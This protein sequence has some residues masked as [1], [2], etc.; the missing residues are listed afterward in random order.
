[1]K[2]SSPNNFLNSP[3][4]SSFKPM[5]NYRLLNNIFGWIT[6]VIATVVYMLTVEPTV[7]YWDCGEFI[8][9]AYKL[10]V[11][12]PPGAPLFMMIAR[13]FTLMAGDDVTQVAKWVNILSGLCSSF[14]IL[15]LFWS[16]TAF[17]KKIV[18]KSGELDQGKTIAIVGSGLVG[19]LAYTFT[20]SFWFSA[21]EGEVYAMSSFFTAI[22]FWMI[23][24]WESV[25]DE[26]HSD[27]WLILIAYTMG[28]SIGVHLLN[29]LAIPALA[30]VYYF[31]KYKPTTKGVFI[32]GGIGVGT[33]LFIQYGIIP[34]VVSIAS[35]FELFFVNSMGLP[36]NSGLIIYAILIVAVLA[37]G[38]YYTTK[39]NPMPIANTLLLAFT[40][41]L[42]GYSSYALIVIRSSA[43]PPMDENDPSNVFSL[44]AYLNREQYGDR[45]L[46][47]GQYYNT[48]M[49]I[50]REKRQYKMEDGK[51]VYY[52]G[53]KDG[54]DSYLIGDDRKESIPVYVKEL[55][56]FFPRMYS[57]QSHHIQSYKSWA[58][59][60]GKKVRLKNRPDVDE[61]V[62]P[63]FVENLTFFFK[64][65][66][67]HMYFRYFMWNFAGR[68]NNIQ[69]H[70]GIVEGNWI[71][72]IPF[73]DNYLLGSQ[74]GLPDDMAS[75]HGRNHF[76]LLPLILGLI[77]IYYQFSWDSKDGFVV[78]LLF[79]FTGLAIVLYLN[80]YPNQPRERDY[81]YAASFY[82]F[83]IWIG[84]AVLAIYDFLSK[85]V[86]ASIS[87]AI[88]T[89]ACL[90]AAPVVLASDGWNDHDRSG[91]YMAHDLAHNYLNSC[92]PNA[93]LFT[94]G[95]NDTFPLW[96]AQEVEGIRTDVRVVNLSLL[97]TDWYINQMKRRAYESAPLPISFTE[98]QIRQGTRDFLPIV[99]KGL[100]GYTDLKRIM[101][102]IVSDKPGAKE[103]IYGDIT[104]YIPT[105]K[106]S[107]PVDSA[108]IIDN[109][110]VPRKD[111]DKVLSSLNWEIDKRYV[112]KNDMAVMS[113]LAN[114]N[115]ERPVYFAVTV[116]NDAYLNLE[117]FF[118]LEGLAYRVVPVRAKLGAYRGRVNTDVMYDNVMNKFKWG[119]INNPELYM[120]PETKRLTTSLRIH[121]TRLAEALMEENK[122]DSAIAVLDKLITEVPNETVPYNFL[123]ISV[124]ELYY[125]LEQTEK[126]NTVVKILADTYDAH[127][128][129]Y[130]KM[131]PRFLSMAQTEVSEAISITQRLL[132]AT[133]T[134]QQDELADEIEAKFNVVQDK[135]LEVI[136]E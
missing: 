2:P 65:Q 75:N 9:A 84:L 27:R 68:Q 60:K 34:G 107:I 128:H 88:A 96:Y 11:G 18:S 70:G 76:Y 109:E 90:I 38:L 8:A 7:S 23:L 21:V 33:L 129:Y 135:Y 15:F 64:Y 47:Y 122:N 127:L 52:P 37:G 108:Y 19:A 59:I 106:F 5:N 62:Q 78:F 112:I 101:N 114:N 44:L 32:A 85:K 89:G 130:L 46:L 104:N 95:D 121:M 82:A 100:E 45:P 36:F 115:W 35:K 132:E 30:Y 117:N 29:L 3:L 110:I 28:L 123:M 12:H 118:Q 43:N 41:I 31:K 48:P 116:G 69:G 1:M 24:K 42:I 99:E 93:I 87:A 119:G 83:S 131:K 133:M 103:D 120:D 61:I 81:A 125:E 58:N 102:F 63:T 73:I 98:D 71:S 6:F 14:T 126:A 25:A 55:C 77:G 53:E 22:V 10:Q 16:I 51:P 54:E 49:E 39:L 136:E 124:A 91:R 72:G 79:F 105:K 113:I 134:Y 50:D 111:A 80:Q 67:G 94:N 17:A 4:S 56:T 13:I 26:K 74:E 97:G 40:V 57:S 20:D 92:A 66:I 86:P